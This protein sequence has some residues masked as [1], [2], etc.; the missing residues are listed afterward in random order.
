MYGYYLPHYAREY[1]Q[2]WRRYDRF[3]RLRRSLDIPGCSLLE[4][5]TRYQSDH[6]FQYG[7]DRQVQLKDEYREVLLFTPA[8]IG[9]IMYHLRVTDVQRVG[10]KNLAVELERQELVQEV[11]SLRAQ[12]GEF[13]A[14]A[15]DM[16][17]RLAWEEG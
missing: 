5:K 4:R 13:E 12:H 11:V 6:P 10:A 14:R 15:G 2:G 3:L 7:T 1:Q 8:D 9:L 16:Y 17:E